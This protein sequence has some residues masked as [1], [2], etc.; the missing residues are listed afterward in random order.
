M[1]RRK[2]LFSS[3]LCHDEERILMGDATSIAEII[4]GPFYSLGNEKSLLKGVAKN[5]LR[6]IFS[7]QFLRR[8][9]LSP[10]KFCEHFSFKKPAYC[11]IEEES[12]AFWLVRLICKGRIFL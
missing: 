7:S 11:T 9:F 8:E 1:R 4:R 2:C 6:N 5:F 3:L 10:T 12:K